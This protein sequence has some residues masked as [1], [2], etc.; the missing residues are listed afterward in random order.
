M[1]EKSDNDVFF[2]GNKIPDRP[3]GRNIIVFKNLRL[4]KRGESEEADGAVFR[5]IVPG[6]PLF[7]MGYAR[8]FPVNVKSF[9][10]VKRCQ[11]QQQHACYGNPQSLFFFSYD[12]LICKISGSN[13]HSQYL[14][15]M[16][17]THKC[18]VHLVTLSES[19]LLFTVS[20]SYMTRLETACCFSLCHFTYPARNRTFPVPYHTYQ[21]LWHSWL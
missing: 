16:I 3:A 5:G 14:Q 4:D 9:H 1:R 21:V 18:P 11:Y 6:V 19:K 20:I 13:H 7:V 15:T 8:M 17:Y 2:P 12:P 10:E